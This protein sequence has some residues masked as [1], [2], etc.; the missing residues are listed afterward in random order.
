MKNYVGE[1]ITAIIMG[2]GGFLAWLAER[3]KRK[4]QDKKDIVEYYQDSLDDLEKRWSKKF[5]DLEADIKKL[6]ENVNL[7]KSKYASLK[8]EFDKYREEHK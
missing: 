8:K 3:K 2:S 7:W 4:I 1:F 6:R 5:E